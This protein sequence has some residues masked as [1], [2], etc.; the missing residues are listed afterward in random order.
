MNPQCEIGIYYF[1]SLYTPIGNLSSEMFKSNT[2][3]KL[4]F[5]INTEPY[6]VTESYLQ[7]APRARLLSRWT[8]TLESFKV[9][10]S[11]AL[12]R[13]LYSDWSTGY[14][15]KDIIISNFHMWFFYISLTKILVCQ[16]LWIL[17]YNDLKVSCKSHSLNEFTIGFILQV[18]ILWFCKNIK[19]TFFWNMGIRARKIH[20]VYFKKKNGTHSTTTNETP[21]T[22]N[23]RSR[24][25]NYTEF[26]ILY[27]IIHQNQR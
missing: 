27:D 19:K 13:L 10:F 11:I 22:V 12:F 20:C 8:V 3:S 2:P 16:K 21:L 4:H 24:N 14:I 15:P 6:N 9:S 5:S 23:K 25:G 26:L 18:V 7:P 1:I 17:S